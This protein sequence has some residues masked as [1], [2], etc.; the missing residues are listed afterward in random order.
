MAKEMDKKE[1]GEK[2]RRKKNI[3]DGMK[4]EYC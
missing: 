2:S 3:T 4:W 1:E